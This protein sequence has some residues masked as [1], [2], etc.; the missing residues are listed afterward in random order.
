MRVSRKTALTP[1]L[2]AKPSQ[3]AYHM[4]ETNA[5]VVPFTPP[6]PVRADS[7]MMALVPGGALLWTWPT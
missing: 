2:A 7:P 3:S 5:F 1:L 6:P 4:L